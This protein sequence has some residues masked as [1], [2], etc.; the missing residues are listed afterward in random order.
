MKQ[1]LNLVL[2]TGVFLTG[3]VS[4]STFD[5]KQDE[6]MVC[7][8]KAQSDLNACSSARS[9]LD[10][11]LTAANQE[12]GVFRQA[13]EARQR[14]LDEL[15]N[16]EKQL[17]ERLSKE[18]TDKNLEIE[19]VGGQ[20]VVRMPDKAVFKSGSADILPQ[21]TEVLDKLAD[22][23]KDSVN[24]IRVEGHTDDTPI[25]GKLKAKYPSNW[26][27]SAA[28]AFA[29][30]RYFETKHF[31]NP[32]RL[33]SLG[34]SMYHPVAPNDSEENKQRNRRIEIVLKPAAEPEPAKVPAAAEPAPTTP[35]APATKP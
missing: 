16:Q 5:K 27:L 23:I 17:R 26:E 24:V 6:L 14:K 29:V 22:A 18:L 12:L 7:Q 1:L 10:T 11:K 13:A 20:I 2:V 4:T 28:R 33:E 30:A 19:Q 3:C 15:Q 35:V 25:S 34:F 32:K 9:E 21:D 31:I 8:K